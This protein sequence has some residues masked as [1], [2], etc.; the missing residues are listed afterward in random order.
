M[1]GRPPGPLPAVR[2]TVDF[3]SGGTFFEVEGL[4]INGT[5]SSGTPGPISRVIGTLVCNPG[6]T[7]EVIHDTTSVPLSSRGTAGFSGSL[8]SIQTPCNNPL[9]LIRIAQPA[10]AFGRWIATG[11]VR[12]FGHGFFSDR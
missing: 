3:K 5:A 2:P 8:G 11:A 10:G 4:V 6:Q 1:A 9:F 12:S 7:D